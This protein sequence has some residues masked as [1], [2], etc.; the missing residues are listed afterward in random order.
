MLFYWS[1]D[2]HNYEFACWFRV[3][4]IRS[5]ACGFILWVPYM[6]GFHGFLW[7]HGSIVDC[8]HCM[9]P[10]SIRVLWDCGVSEFHGHG[11]Y[12]GSME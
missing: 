3:L 1:H 9:A 6:H 10:C 5:V 4:A 2:F 8:D 12:H 7:F 11:F